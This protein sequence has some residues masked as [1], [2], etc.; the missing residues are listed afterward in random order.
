MNS[1]TKN[2]YNIQSVH[3]RLKKQNKTKSPILPM[4]YLPEEATKNALD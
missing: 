1:R 4:Y 3:I 2:L